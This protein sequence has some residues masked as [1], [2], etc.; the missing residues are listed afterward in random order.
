MIATAPIDAQKATTRIVRA[1]APV[2]FHNHPQAVRV[3]LACRT[4]TPPRLRCILNVYGEFRLIERVSIG[5]RPVK[6]H[7]ARVFED[8]SGWVTYSRARSL[9]LNPS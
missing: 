9:Y 1:L 5:V 2:A 4:T 8:F 6:R 7:R 3:T